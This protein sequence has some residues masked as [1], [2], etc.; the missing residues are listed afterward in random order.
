ME[1]G[2][3]QS[4]QRPSG[5]IEGSP[6]LAGKEGP[7]EG[8]DLHIPSPL[9][10]TEADERKHKRKLQEFKQYLVDT[11]VVRVLVERETVVITYKSSS[12]LIVP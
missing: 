5:V 9:S 8:H 4:A 3:A 11:R 7:S 10:F 1:E 2:P 12:N 6:P